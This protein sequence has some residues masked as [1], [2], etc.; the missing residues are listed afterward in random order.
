M[1]KIKSVFPQPAQDIIQMSVEAFETSDMMIMLTDQVGRNHAIMKYPMFVGDNSVQF[2]IP[3]QIESGAYILK[4][5]SATSG[6][7]DAVPI[8]IIR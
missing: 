4:L 5:M 6:L 2:T 7:L 3:A 1:K 8:H